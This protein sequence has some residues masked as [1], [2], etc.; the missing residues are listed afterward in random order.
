MNR[1]ILLILIGLVFINQACGQV[2]N[3]AQIKTENVVGNGYTLTLEPFTVKGFNGLHSFAVAQNEGKWLLIGGRTDGL[4]GRRPFE[5]FLEKDNNTNIIVIDP[6]TKESWSSDVTDLPSALREQLQS[7]NMQFIQ[8]G[9]TLYLIGGYGYSRTERDHITHNKLTAVKVDE[10]ISAIRKGDPIA[11]YFRQISNDTFALTGGQIGKIGD[12]FYLVGGQKFDGRYNPMGPDH[13][14]GFSQEYSNQIRKFRITDDGKKLSVDNL[15]AI[16]DNANLHRR[17]FNMIPQMFPN[18]VPGFTVFSGVFQVGDNIPYTNTVDVYA[19]KH[20]VN[21]EFTQY[22][23]HYHSA[24]VA[25]YDELNQ[26]MENIFF[27]GIS[28][29]EEN[30]G[31]LTKNDD[32]PFT[33][34]I[35]KVVRDKDGQ[36]RETKIGEMPGFLGASAEFI[37]HPKIPRYENDVVKLNELSDR[38]ILL[39]YFVG[40]IESTGKSVFFRFGSDQS[41]TNKLIF[42]VWLTKSKPKQVN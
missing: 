21:K 39:G 22:L 20:I 10:L 9:K 27:G 35:G 42:E 29:F 3:K 33:K 16:T 7:T 5:A 4:H 1:K 15:A 41:S 31:S 11:A 13:G 2:A 14:P 25:L 36:M 26:R 8:Q 23:N 30:Q 6:E 37:L 28:Q 24:K 12:T 18:K 38:R 19:G 17:D 34:V 32:V 40:G